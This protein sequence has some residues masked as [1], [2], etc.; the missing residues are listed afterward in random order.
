MYES[1]SSGSEAREGGLRSKYVL[2]TVIYTVVLNVL[3][4]YTFMGVARVRP[5]NH[6]VP[7]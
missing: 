5:V 2:N 7:F 1:T 3:I 4:C 6:I